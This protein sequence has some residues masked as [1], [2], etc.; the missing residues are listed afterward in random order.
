VALTRI[1]LLHFTGPPHAGGIEQLLAAQAEALTAAGHEV[2][3]V[4][5]DGGPLPAAAV[6]VVPEMAPRHPAVSAGRAAWPAGLP[7]PAHPVV[8][9]LI[10]LLSARLHGCD[11][12]W[13]HNALTVTLNPFLTRALLVL[14]KDSV[15]AHWVVWCEDTTALSR[16]HPAADPGVIHELAE[17]LGGAVCVTISESRRA[18]L[19]SIFALPPDDIAVIRPPLDVEAWLSLSEDVKLIRKMIPLHAADPFVFVPA[20][21]LAHKGL[22]RAVAVTRALRR[23]GAHPLVMVSGAASPHEPQE[24]AALLDR[25]RSRAHELGVSDTFVVL[26]AILGREPAQRNVR[27]MLAICDVV[28]L[29]SHEEGF[30]LPLL[31]AAALRVQIVC[32]DLPVF[33]KTGGTAAHYFPADAPDDDVARLILR[34]AGS[35]AN[36][37]RRQALASQQAFTDAVQELAA[38][39]SE[40][41]RPR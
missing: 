25:L 39:V 41:C 12:C 32:T 35:P 28:L 30:G 15:V 31:E 33:R 23:C 3:L 10:A 24:S 7:S 5:G 8:T 36:R 29:P 34:A 9:R 19:A 26:S 27:D 40:S 14:M 17:G 6:H 18:E 16:F 13:V 20:K 37:A 4:V 22:E 11:Q 21:L 2:H 38:R 1:A